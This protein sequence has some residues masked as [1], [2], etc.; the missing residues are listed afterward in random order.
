MIELGRR[1]KLQ[2]VKKVE[3]GVY[4]GEKADAK[5][6]ERVLLPAKQVPAE[7][8]V[9]DEL[10]VFIYR[11]SADR[12]I[13]TTRVPALELHQTAVVKVAE[14]GKIGAFLDWGLEKDLLLPYKEQT[15]NKTMLI[16]EGLFYAMSSVSAAFIQSLAVGPLAGKM[17]G[18]MFWFFE[19]RFTVLPVL[20]T[21]PVFLLLGWLIPCM[22]YDNAA[23]CSIVD[24]LR[25][26][27]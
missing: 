12:L 11:D 4:L 1:Q 9:G 2:V 6:Q 16:Y 21:I 8:K 25:D 3:F 18:S 14:V 5:E 15:V 20:L 17:L 23:K 22:M 13:A 19:Y 27:Q 7:T 24:Q 10:E 26:A